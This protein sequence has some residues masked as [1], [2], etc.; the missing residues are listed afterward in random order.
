MPIDI[1]TTLN[2][3]PTTFSN[4]GIESAALE[5]LRDKAGI[6]GTKLVCGSGV[7]GACTILVDGQ[8][9]CSCLLPATALEGRQV[10]TVEA[11]GPEKLHPVQKAFLAHD[12]LQCGYCTPGFINEGIAFY[13]RWRS[14]KGK[15]RP[16]REEV[17]E[18]LA[19][20]L[21]RCGAYQGIYEA[22]QSACEG[23]YDGPEM[24]DYLRVDGIPKVTGQAKFTTDVQLPGQLVGAIA[25]SPYPHARIRSID[26]S[27]AQA[28]PGVKAVMLV[29]E[30]KVS[31][32]EGEAIAAIAATDQATAHAAVELIRIDWEPLPFVV[33]PRTARQPEAP[34]IYAAEK[35]DMPVASEGPALPGSLDGNVR[36]AMFSLSSA[37]KGKARRMTKALPTDTQYNYQATFSTPTQFHTTLEPHCAVADWK[38]D[39][40]LTVYASTQS[41]FYLAEDIAKHFKLKREDVEVIADYVGGAFGSKL[42]L[43]TEALVAIKLS[44]AAGAPV[45]VVYS[46]A[47]ELS[48]TGYRPSADIEVAITVDPD[49][50]NPGYTMRGYSNA[51]VAIGSNVADISGLAYTG[52]AK[53]LE[54][55]DVLTH[56]QP[57]CAFRGPGGPAACF[58]LEQAIDQLAHQMGQDPV[59]FR[60]K[61]EEDPGY[62][63]L[64]DW[65]EKLPLW[66]DRPA[67]ASQTGRFKRGVGLSIGAWMHLY[68]TTAE[69]EV[70]AGPQ[71]ITV[72]NA[73]QDMGQGAKTV[74]AKAAADAFGLPI[75][76]IRYQAGRSDL[77]IGPSSG[78]SRTTATIYPAAYE[79]AEKVIAALVAQAEKNLLL[80]DAKAVPGGIAHAGGMLPW[81]E[82]LPKLKPVKEKAT[83][84]RNPGFSVMG[85]MP[86]PQ[87]L[88]LGEGRSCGAYVI[89]VEVDTLLGKVRVTQV[90][91]AMR[92]GKIHARPMALSQCY[93]GVIQGIGH[94][95][96]E[97]RA[98]CPTTGRNLTRNLE[99]YRIPGIGDIPPMHIDFLEEGFDFAKQKGIGLA[100]LCTTPVAGA[101]A[102]AIF[103]ATGFRMLQAP[104]RPQDILAASHA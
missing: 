67:F 33:D 53:N 102:N 64:F 21:C 63:A 37:D 15:T 41:V 39:G 56:M 46:R 27:A 65:V 80:I 48:E 32:Y 38:A 99:D 96:Y 97:D 8:A 14:D 30:D 35:A 68:M 95:L 40:K 16:T 5:L 10:Q 66:R 103:H 78:G 52:I 34:F 82:A 85:M 12:A 6:T 13:N 88:T 84:G 73:V 26:L 59:A 74:L 91:G 81:T 11:H 36:K 72:S 62:V 44:R 90:Q 101:V 55:Y 20:H 31:R 17:A 29:K 100:E 58:T 94:V 51:G 24:P 87:G 93:G 43:R 92:V 57:G 61:W 60:R 19:G 2:G 9:R 70:E 98:L 22:M 50:R 45:S 54:D 25:R 89:E 23:T 83:R 1:R 18:G 49:G 104:I 71:G 3:K 76:Q 86:L 47:E 28:L 69:V 7:C 75:H 79:A 42:P 4:V 77:L